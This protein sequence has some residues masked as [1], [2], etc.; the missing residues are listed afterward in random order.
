M[1][2]RAHS[3]TAIPENGTWGSDDDEIDN[4]NDNKMWGGPY[5]PQM[6]LPLGTISEMGENEQ[7]KNSTS[8]MVS[9]GCMDSALVAET[10]TRAA[11]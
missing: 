4:N 1:P 2:F 3:L 7:P 8:G 11:D 10:Q 9:D 6:P 5:W